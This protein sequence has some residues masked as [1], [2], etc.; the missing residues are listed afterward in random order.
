MG[1]NI[2]PNVLSKET[3]LWTLYVDIRSMTNDDEAVKLAIENVLKGRVDLFS[4]QVHPGVGYVDCDPDSQL[5]RAARWTLEKEGIPYRIIEGFGASDS[6]YFAG[7][8]ADLF[9]FGPIG[10]NIHG[11]NE[12]VSIDSLRT[13]SEVYHT[14]IDVLLRKRDSF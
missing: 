5:I 11:V 10:D 6:R 4:L 9:D 8:G 14:L 3:D 13:T 12:W 2:C 7:E 1:T